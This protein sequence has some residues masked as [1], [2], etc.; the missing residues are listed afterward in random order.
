MAGATASANA[1]KSTAG[2]MYGKDVNYV[3]FAKSNI[4]QAEMNTVI[5]EVQKTG[6]ILAIGTFVAGTTDSVNVSHEGPAVTMGSDF[7]G[8]TGVTSSATL[9][10]S[11]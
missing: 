11:W 1:G 7:V 2:E 9:H 5:R 10:T 6:T 3:N 4:T 8:A